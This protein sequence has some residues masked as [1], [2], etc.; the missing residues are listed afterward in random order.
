MRGIFRRG[1]WIIFAVILLLVLL[2]ICA[3]HFGWV[4]TSEGGSNVP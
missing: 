4:A 2:L 1:D 3:I